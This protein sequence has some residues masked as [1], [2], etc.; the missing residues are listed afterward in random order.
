MAR[1]AQGP[2]AHPSASLSQEPE[3]CRPHSTPA[4]LTPSSEC[5]GNG[6]DK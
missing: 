4:R 2:L 5:L 1:G 3:A 6:G